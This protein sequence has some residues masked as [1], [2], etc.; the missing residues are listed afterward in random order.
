MRLLPTHQLGKLTRCRNGRL[1]SAKCRLRRVAV[2]ILHR[3]LR[4]VGRSVG[5]SIG[6]VGCQIGYRPEAN[7]PDRTSSFVLI[8]VANFSLPASSSV[9]P[10]A[11]P[12]AQQSVCTSVHPSSVR[13][14]VLPSV[15]SSFRPSVFQPIRQ[16]AWSSWSGITECT[17]SQGVAHRR[18]ST[19]VMTGRRGR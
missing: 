15:H 16:S 9:R 3:T 4:S 2:T 8:V 14:S 17:R 13:L 10:P 6:L 12:P 18:I 5:R 7:P 1:S 19:S 11:R